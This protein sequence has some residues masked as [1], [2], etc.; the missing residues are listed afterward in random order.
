M[1]KI[2]SCLILLVL[3]LALICLEGCSVNT[4]TIDR[5]RGNKDSSRSGYS[6]YYLNN[7]GTGM[8]AFP[9]QF[10][11]TNEEDIINE[12]LTA[13]KEDPSDAAYSAVIKDPVVLDH[14]EYDRSTRYVSLYFEAGY[15]ALKKEE[16]LLTRG[17]IVKTLTQLSNIIQYVSF[18]VDGEG[19]TNEEGKLLKMTEEDFTTEITND[20][21]R[22]EDAK[23]TLYFFNKDAT[24]LAASE[25]SQ[26]YYNYGRD[27]LANVILDALLRGP[28]TDDCLPSIPNDVIVRSVHINDGLCT[29]DF[30]NAIIES[31]KKKQ[32]ELTIYSVVNT[33]CD[34]SDVDEVQITV[35]GSTVLDPVNKLDIS[36][37]L[38]PRMDLVAKPEGI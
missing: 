36:G 18:Y 14:F 23:F 9:Y 22:L 27:S 20:L 24:K 34:M 31:V 1:K 13:L 4:E 26:K 19:L 25:V 5:L 30:N 37:H 2:Y 3:L 11:S 10:T 6:I 32:F 21:E 29:V 7:S 16:E 15:N 8:G 28:V 33:L 35:E 38:K 17:S 12:C